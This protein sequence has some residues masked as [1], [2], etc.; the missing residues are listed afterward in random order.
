MKKLFIVG[1]LGLVLLEIANVYFIMPMPGSQRM[2]SVDAAYTIYRW[3][4]T[5]RLLFGAIALAGGI[6]T[7]RAGGRRRW[8]VPASL[9]LVGAV[10]YVV[11]FRMAADQMFR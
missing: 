11:N 2:R 6:A 9:A 8:L 3:R 10:A 4:W 1:V 5:L 7:W